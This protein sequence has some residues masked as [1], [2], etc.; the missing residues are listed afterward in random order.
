VYAGKL[1]RGFSEQ[2]KREMLQRLAPLKIRAQPVAAN[3]KRFPKAQWVQPAP[4]GPKTRI[5]A[6]AGSSFR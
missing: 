2:D 3:R 4:P 6:S 1:E 5:S